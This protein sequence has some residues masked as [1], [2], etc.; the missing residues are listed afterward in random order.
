MLRASQILVR[1]FALALSAA[2]LVACGQRGP[3]YLPT[4]PEAAQRATLPQTLTP[5]LL[6]DDASPPAPQLPP[7]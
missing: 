2:S 4:A 5:Q 3:L 7:R 1:S 6:N